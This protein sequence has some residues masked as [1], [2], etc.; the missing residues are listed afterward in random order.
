MVLSDRAGRFEG[1]ETIRSVSREEVSQITLSFELER[2]PDAA[3]AD[4][5][6][7]VARTRG[8][9]PQEADESVISKV[10]AD[11][12]A[13]MWLA[14]AS[15][16]H[17]ALE[18]TDYADR[19]VK[20]R[21]QSLPGVASI[22]IGGQRRYAMRIW[23]E[24]ARLAAFGITPQDVEEALRSRNLEVPGGR[25]EGREREFAVVTETDLRTPEQFN[26]LI[27]RQ[28]NGYPVRLRDIGRAELGAEDERNAVRVN[29]RP[30]VGLGVVKQST[31]N[32]LEVA[33]AVKAE[34]AHITA[35]LPEG[36]RLG[37]AFDSSLFIERSIDEVFKTLWQALLL[38][39]CVTFLF[40]RSV[41]A[42]VIPLVTIPVSLVGAFIFVYAL[43]FS[44]N[45]L[46]LLALVLAIGLVVD[47]AIV[48]L[49]NI[50]RRI[51]AGM[52]PRR[53]A[54]EGSG[55]I[56]FAV[57]A[58]TLTLATVFA[59]LAYMSGNT[60]RLFREFALA[61]S[62]AVLVSGFVALSLSP[63]MCSRMLA[64][65]SAHGRLYQLSER[66][67]ERIN[68]AYRRLLAATLAT[69]P[70][71]VLVGVLVGAASGL[72]VTQTPSELAPVEDRGTII[73]IVSGPEGATMAYTDRYAR[74][75]ET[76]LAE[77]PEIAGYFMV[78]A[79]GL[80]RPSPVNVAMAFVSLKPWEERTRKQQ[81]IAA[82]LVPKF[83]SLPGVLAFPINPA[84]L[85]QSFRQTPI[86]FVI[87][88]SS[89]PELQEFVERLMAEASAYPGIVNLDSDLKLNKPEL[90][91]TVD[92]DKAADVGVEIAAIGTTLE[93]LL[94]GRQVTRFKREGEQYDVV[95]QI[96]EDER[97]VPADLGSIYV[98]GRD[99]RLMRL[100]NLVGVKETVAAKELNHFN[101]LRA[102]ILQGN[103]AP[104]YTLGDALGFLEKTATEV[105]PPT[106]RT[107]LDG[108]S[109][110]FRESSTALYLTFGLALVFIYLVL[111]A[112]FESFID[113]FV[114]LLTVPLGVT[115]ALGALKL[116]GGTLNVYSE[117]GLVM[118]IGLI[119]KN[120]ILIVE[121]ANRLR[122]RGLD[123]MAA[124]QEAAAL[125]LRPILMTTSAMILGALP[126]ALAGGPGAESRAPIGWV[127]VGGLSFGTLLTLFVIPTAY[128]LLARRDRA[129][130]AEA[131]EPS[132]TPEP[133]ALAEFR[134]P[135]S[136]R[137]WAQ[138]R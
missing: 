41:R 27:I 37:I 132:P 88:G 97:R 81:A 114:I 71:V 13:I 61:V 48:M 5:R 17:S 136:R 4:V 95:I 62:A 51:E 67:L 45:V 38:V 123:P 87:Q 63:M 68:A 112:Q 124:V 52:D 107:D 50:H 91:V 100:D 85:G 11:A 22:I 64:Q 56:A 108:Q 39:L 92:R 90:R 7:R 70:L 57:V 31:A 15:D 106:A 58:M 133:A 118:L 2:D 84:P 78:V 119:T 98:R 73:G 55:E 18:I 20:D 93:T 75:I 94:G 125:R 42:T 65:E 138:R 74:R 131:Y 44:V 134:S 110:E 69:R 72:M 26:D 128:T 36:M 35:G 40:L 12:Q 116:S 115:G 10:E 101:R 9:L 122:S 104:G 126:L 34:L 121:F 14:L 103:V 19:Y 96:A 23:L 28:S 66:V 86:Q 129:T 137:E 60:G 43:G 113:P 33:Q 130:G 49:E 1:I 82:D 120:G 127:I 25:I 30:A 32:T 8:V 76:M 99:G 80:D 24:R 105:L 6:D 21:L 16:R 29:G 102:A 117:I 111:A 54:F 135:Q 83:M 109:R 3:A 47:D 79:P 59:P 53:A 89:Y 77:V 46:T